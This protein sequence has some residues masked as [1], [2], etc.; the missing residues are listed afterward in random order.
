MAEG[1]AAPSLQRT[2]RRPRP[3]TRQPRGWLAAELGRS[4]GLRPRLTG[5]HP[6]PPPNCK[7]KGSSD[8]A[9]TR[10]ILHSLP[11]S[12]PLSL[13]FS[14]LCFSEGLRG[15]PELVGEEVFPTNGSMLCVRA[16]RADRADLYCAHS[17][18]PLPAGSPGRSCSGEREVEQPWPPRGGARVGAVKT[19]QGES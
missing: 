9:E 16:P 2:G 5:A 14:L 8:E 17:G 3:V 19:E 10:Y 13:G 12:R 11:H 4:P 7:V 6:A 1:T 15:W 18:S